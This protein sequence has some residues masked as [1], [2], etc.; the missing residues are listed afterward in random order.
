MGERNEKIHSSQR[1]LVARPYSMDSVVH[2]ERQVTHLI[3]DLL[4]KFD[5]FAAS[6]RSIDIGNWFQL[7]AFDVI[8]AVS[9]TK[10]F[11]FVAQANDDGTFTRI[12]RSLA[13]T[14]W[15]M[16]VP[17]IFNFHQKY[18]LPVFGNFLRAN[19]RNDFFFNFAKSEVQDRRDKGGIDN[20]LVGQLFQA[21]HS[22]TE[23]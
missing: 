13:N 11:G 1:R 23:L 20:D 2:L 9:F 12:E 21:A 18:I 10:P 22:K 15:L 8:G 17:W 19:D 5:A 16:H 3:D 6:S 4:I 14:A 7:F